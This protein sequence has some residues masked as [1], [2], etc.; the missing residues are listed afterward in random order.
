MNNPEDD[1]R[2][3]PTTDPREE[4]AADEAAGARL[5]FIVGRME[6]MN[7][8]E[9]DDRDYPTTDPREEIAADEAAG[10]FLVFIVV[11]LVALLTGCLILRGLL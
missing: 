11:L 4:I 3:Y 8:P 6:T 1:D 7:N 10:A 5:V 2:D 9:D